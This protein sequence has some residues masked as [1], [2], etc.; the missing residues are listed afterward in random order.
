MWVSAGFGILRVA[1]FL[2]SLSARALPWLHLDPLSDAPYSAL[3]PLLREVEH[4]PGVREFGVYTPLGSL[5]LSAVPFISIGQ[6]GHA[7]LQK[8][9]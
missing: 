7:V 2:A 4:L 9:T 5:G 8:H 3:L 1:A 6:H